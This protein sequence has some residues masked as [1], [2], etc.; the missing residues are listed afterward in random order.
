MSRKT[1][2]AQMCD[3]SADKINQEYSAHAMQVG[4]KMDLISKLETEIQEH[5][6][7][8]FKLR[9]EADA[10]PKVPVAAVP[11]DLSSE[12]EHA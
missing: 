9:K 10:L 2:S 11:R 1:E 8:L 7:L 12:E 6:N 3:R 5:K 4:H